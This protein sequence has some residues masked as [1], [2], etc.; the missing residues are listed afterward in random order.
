MGI[1]GA[2]IQRLMTL[3]KRKRSRHFKKWSIVHNAHSLRLDRNI[4][5]VHLR[6]KG[7]NLVTRKREQITFIRQEV[8]CRYIYI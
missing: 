8:S 7:E 5:M 2:C 4:I 6:A 3:E 1:T